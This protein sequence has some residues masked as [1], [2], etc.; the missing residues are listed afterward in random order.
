M[1][2]TKVANKTLV[3]E[4]PPHNPPEIP[5]IKLTGGILGGIIDGDCGVSQHVDH[6]HVTR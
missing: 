2:A 1:Y 4:L 5:I 6:K 3:D